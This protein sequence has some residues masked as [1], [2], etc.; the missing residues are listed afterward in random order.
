MTAL[1]A[2]LARLLR[3]AAQRMERTHPLSLMGEMDAPQSQDMPPA[4]SPEEALALARADWSDRL[5][6]DGCLLPGGVAEIHRLSALLPL[7]P[8]T[9]LL[10]A[11]RDAGG[12][13]AAVIAQRGAWVAAHQHD[14]LL[15]RRM[16]AR[17]RPQGKRASVLP[18]DPEA[19]AFRLHYHHHALALEPL[20][21]GGRLDRLLPAL[22]A[23]LKPEAQLVLLEVVQGK[24]GRPGFE[25]W[26]ELEGRSRPPP[27]RPAAE[28]A[29]QAAGFQLHVAED[30]GRRQ[31]TAILAAWARLLESLRAESRPSG[32]RAAA[33][34]A[35]AELWLL[36]HRLLAEGAIG[37]L[38]WHATLRR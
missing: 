34:V 19:P 23:A 24:P 6:D 27:P 26:L 4:L 33:L 31:A 22:A 36:R 30:A 11:G 38:R 9:T 20:S 15:A 18:W 35:E 37:L 12:A 8:A 1:T 2:S 21:G 29:L 10:L 13:G 28:A 3:R 32:L 14:P 17:L 25:R 5:W 16:A 7:S